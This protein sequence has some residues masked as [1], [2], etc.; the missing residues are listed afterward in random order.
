[1]IE[2]IEVVPAATPWSSVSCGTSDVA[3]PEYGITH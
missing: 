2:D 1:V 3:V